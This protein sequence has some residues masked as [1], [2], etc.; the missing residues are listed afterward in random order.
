MILG[1]RFLS[2]WQVIENHFRILSILQTLLLFPF[3]CNSLEG[4]AAQKVQVFS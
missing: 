4:T 3:F 2:F 1:G